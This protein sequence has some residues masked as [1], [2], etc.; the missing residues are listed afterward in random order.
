MTSYADDFYFV[1]TE[2]VRFA[3]MDLAELTNRPFQ[4]IFCRLPKPAK[5]NSE[6]DCGS[7]A[8]ERLHKLAEAA[9]KRS[10]YPG[11]LDET[12]V[13]EELKKGL[14][15]R[16]IDEGAEIDVANA[17]HVVSESIA[18]AA[19]S[20]KKI[21]YLIPCRLDD[22]HK[23][24]NFSLGPVAFWRREERFG[25][26]AP[27]LEEYGKN[28][29]VEKSLLDGAQKYYAAFKWIAEIK[30]GEASPK[31]SQAR[32]IQIARHALDCLHLLL[33]P[34][35][36]DMQSGGRTFEPD[37]RGLI[38]VQGKTVDISNSI[39]WHGTYLGDDWWAKLHSRNY[40]E[41]IRLMALA[42][43]DAH[44][45]HDYAP[46]AQRFLDAA[47]WYGEAVRDEF[48]A[49]R[50][51]KYVT[52][53]ERVLATKQDDEITKTLSR[54]GA[55]LL[56]YAGYESNDHER[57]IKRA[58]RFR[59]QLVHGSKSPLNPDGRAIRSMAELSRR[60]CLCFL[61]F[62]GDRLA[63]PSN[64]SQKLD[65]AYARVVEQYYCRVGGP[66]L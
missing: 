63:D 57:D 40:G 11:R 53:M 19:K 61:A 41:S 54:R 47:A 30:L 18:S 8:E 16:F 58:Y 50:A 32:A 28:G 4:D 21:S 43:E 48:A 29:K 23:Q 51:I 52:A 3:K 34:D 20:L 17:E 38:R 14:V 6:L 42:L 2:A 62:C 46:L 60:I 55:A 5:G 22:V 7:V 13:V 45:F 66:L 24:G 36:K 44:K 56:D 27:V 12:I 33:G 37:R 26:L 9:I 49:S 65:T 39:S 35:T 64:T 59:S 31:V 10:T 15:Q 25:A 1:I